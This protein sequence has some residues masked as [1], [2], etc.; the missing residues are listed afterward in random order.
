LLSILF[1]FSYRKDTN[2][3][4]KYLVFFKK[5]KNIKNVVLFSC[6]RQ[7][8]SRLKNFI[9]YF[10]ITKKNPK[11]VLAYI[12]I[13]ITSLLKSREFDQYF[14]IFKKI[15]CFVLVSGIMNLYVKR[16]PVIKKVFL[17]TT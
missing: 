6:I 2:P 10:H 14:K 12:L 5:K 15:F 11:N 3:V 7:S 17:L 1:V 13:L 9:S 16:I 8:L 4:L